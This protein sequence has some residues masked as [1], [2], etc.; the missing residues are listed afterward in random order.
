MLC[1]YQVKH[2]VKS[3]NTLFNLTNQS[4]GSCCTCLELIY[5][6]LGLAKYKIY[7]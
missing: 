4:M 3:T 1:T 6:H 5:K 2:L 7:E